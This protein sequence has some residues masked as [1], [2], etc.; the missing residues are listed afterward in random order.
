LTATTDGPVR[1]RNNALDALRGVA[2]ALVMLRHAFPTQAPGAGIVGIVIFFTLSGYLITGLLQEELAATNRIALRGF[3]RRR[4]ARLAPALLV[5]VA[6]MAAVTLLI[7]PVGDRNA[8]ARTVVVALTWTADLPIG[9]TSPA[10]FHL[11]TLALEEQFYLAWPI[12]LLVLH[13]TGRTVF[14]ICIAVIVCWSAA[15]L[16]TLWLIEEPDLGYALPTSWAVC[17]AIGAFFR[18][19]IG[20]NRFPSLTAVV[21]VSF[22]LLIASMVDLRGHFYTYL[23]AGPA[24]AGLTG[25]LLLRARAHPRLRWPPLRIA[26]WLGHRSY[27]AYLWNYPLSIWL[28][29]HSGT[30]RAILTSALT[31][32]AADLSYRLIERPSQK[33]LSGKPTH[34]LEESTCAA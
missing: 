32:V 20:S 28:D 30:A 13:R 34:P 11:W 19:G 33:A 16:T 12:V 24:I 5:L 18:V 4:L 6:G 23:G 17:M 27:S 9:G 21:A 14:G 7:D 10:A 15:L 2:I 25:V 22:G 1:R 29:A 26:E 3:Y 8:L 31:L